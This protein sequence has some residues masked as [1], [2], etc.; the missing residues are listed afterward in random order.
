MSLYKAYDITTVVEDRLE[1]DDEQIENMDRVVGLILENLSAN[2][3]FYQVPIGREED[4]SH[5]IVRYNK[6]IFNE[7][8]IT[9]EEV[10]L[11]LDFLANKLL[12]EEQVQER[13]GARRRNKNI[14]EGLLFAKHTGKQLILLKLDEAKIIDRITFQ[15]IDGLSLEK[16]YYKIVVVNKNALSDIVVV[17]RNKVIAK[18][19]A[20]G[21]L[22]LERKKDSYVNTTGL[23]DYLEENKLINLDV[24]F[25][26][27]DYTD[28]KEQ[29]REYIF[30]NK[31]F[32]KE[33]VFASL[34]FDKDKYEI[35]ADDLFANHL[36]DDIDVE[37]DID[38]DVVVKK[39]KRT[40]NVSK[41]VKVSI[42]NLHR[43]MKRGN[44]K[45]SGN[46]LTLTVEAEYKE[47]VKQ[48]LEVDL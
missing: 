42:N 40:I 14:S 4:E 37:F 38:N 13:D 34:K 15:P 1:L 11:E 27:D 46:K 33:T 26:E 23:I 9:V 24:D 5:P 17:D 7:E 10:S 45:Y 12:F 41:F 28:V 20:S 39:Y 32:D 31:K 21:F 18:Y 16:Q 25:S 22:E 19:W 29:I 8:E 35:T 43:E 44:V 30:E 36:F 48:M 3:I 2:K 6:K 47:D